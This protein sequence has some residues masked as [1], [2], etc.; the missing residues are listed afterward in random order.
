MRSGV[1]M[2]VE[3]VKA[4]CLL[5]AKSLSV[6]QRY[7]ALIHTAALARCSLQLWFN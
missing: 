7:L 1:R 3:V 4:V 5:G 6:D 2:Q